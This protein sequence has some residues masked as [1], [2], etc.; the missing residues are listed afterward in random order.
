MVP[1]LILYESLCLIFG[2]ETESFLALINIFFSTS[3]SLY[4]ATALAFPCLKSK[5]LNWH[6]MSISM[7]LQLQLA[8]YDHACQD[9]IKYLNLKHGQSTIRK[10]MKIYDDLWDICNILV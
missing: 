4:I 6:G 9:E 10:S 3:Y 5:T 8:W 2:F 1:V 7:K